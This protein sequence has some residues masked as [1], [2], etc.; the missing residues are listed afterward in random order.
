MTDRDNTFST[1]QI[2]AIN[3]CHVSIGKNNQLAA[4]KLKR[5][6]D[7]NRAI[8]DW[9]IND[10]KEETAIKVAEK[11]N[12]Q[13][14]D[15]IQKKILSDLFSRYRELYPKSDA[16]FNFQYIT[17]EVTQ[18]INEQE[19][20]IATYFTYEYNYGENV[21]LVRLKTAYD[22]DPDLIDRAIMT[23]LQNANEEYITAAL[24]KNDLDEVDLIENPDQVID[25]Y[26]KILEN[27]LN[28]RQKRNPGDHCNSCNWPSRCGQ[29]PL[30]NA[31]KITNRVR[32]VK[33]SKTN[34]LKLV[35]CERRAAWNVQ[36]GL[37]KENYIEYETDSQAVKFHK[38]SQQ[39]LV[40][41]ENFADE[42]NTM[43]FNDLTSTE[44]GITREKLY[45]KYQELVLQLRE[46]ENLSIRKSEYN[47]GFTC[48]VDGVENKDGKVVEKKVATIFMGRADLVGY[49]DGTPIIIE[50]KTRPEDVKDQLEAQLYAL[51]V[52]QLM[53]T[54]E[55]IVL[56]VYSLDDVTLQKERRY[57]SS[58]LLSMTEKF[59]DIAK[60]SGSWLPF[61]ALNPK[62]SVGAWCEVC[63]F[64][65]TCLENR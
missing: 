5:W 3:K 46:Y 18:E 4:P 23:K 27:Y 2:K 55:I 64:K 34:L 38:Y 56:H 7:L 60:K 13:F 41:N 14:Y 63:E 9:R 36:Y 12:F 8:I 6:E 65:N 19:Y 57:S 32:E 24:E 49:A 50:L 58:E 21:E 47:V 10:A 35:E 59:E 28:N 33:V 37:P 62:F 45:K 22:P 15:E 31:D 29:F 11:N 25:E 39:M 48:I 61:D 42:K 53:K 30:L 52:S 16:E 1:N 44:D 43:K 51:G 26:F 20:A 40:G 17:K 54:E